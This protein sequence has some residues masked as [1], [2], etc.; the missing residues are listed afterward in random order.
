MLM[1]DQ[2]LR[3]FFLYNISV[4]LP[5]I[6][7]QGLIQDQ[8]T[9]QINTVVEVHLVITIRKKNNSQYRQR[10]ATRTHYNYDRHTTP[11]HYNRSRV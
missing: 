1:H 11:P 8:M 10:S 9:I 6:K 5:M 7:Y 2:N 4:L 3:K